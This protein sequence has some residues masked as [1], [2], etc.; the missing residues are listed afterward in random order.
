MPKNKYTKKDLCVHTYGRG[1]DKKF[2]I[3]TDFIKKDT[4]WHT[5]V[6]PDIEGNKENAIHQALYWL[7]SKDPSMYNVFYGATKIAIAYNGPT[8]YCQTDGTG[9]PLDMY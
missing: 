4:R 6:Y 1:R 3:Y 9:F 5:T 7:N 2:I 8:T